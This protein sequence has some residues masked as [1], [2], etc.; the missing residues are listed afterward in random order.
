MA[1]VLV[2]MYVRQACR[3]DQELATVF[4]DAFL[5]YAKAV[6]AFVP[7]LHRRAGG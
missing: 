1:P 6:P 4:G 3:E 5:G 7:R 2:V